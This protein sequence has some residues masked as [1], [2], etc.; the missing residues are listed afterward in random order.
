MTLTPISAEKA[1]EIIH[2]IYDDIAGQ[3]KTRIEAGGDRDLG[4]EEI[5]SAFGMAD[6]C[7]SE[8]VEGSMR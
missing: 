8:L 6:G 5:I 2:G 1:R 3:Y 7:L 4:A